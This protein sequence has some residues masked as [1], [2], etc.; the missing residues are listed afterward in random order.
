MA[1]VGAPGTLQEAPT[2]AEDLLKLTFY[3]Q[4]APP[5]LNSATLNKE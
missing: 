3:K 4:V 5:E 2:G 1:P